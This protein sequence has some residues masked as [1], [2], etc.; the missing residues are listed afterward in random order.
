MRIDLLVVPDCPNEQPALALLRE[1]LSE[2]GLSGVGVHVTT[3]DNQ[4]EAERRGFVG[5]PTILIDG[6]DPFAVPGA[7][8]ALA[9]RMYPGGQLVPDERKLRLALED[10]L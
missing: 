5:S 7:A 2:M 4:A 8:A 10:A 6:V 1:C 3:I 9:C